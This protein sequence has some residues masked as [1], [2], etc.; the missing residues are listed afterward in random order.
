MAELSEDERIVLNNLQGGLPVRSDPFREL[1]NELDLSADRIVTTL[2]QLDERG[3]LSRFGAVL[4][5]RKMGGDS[6]LAAMRVP[7]D[8]FREVAE[9]VNDYRTVTHNYRREHTLNM[10]FVLSASDPANIDRTMEAIEDETGLEVFNLPKLTEYYV[11]LRFYFESDG[12]V[13]TVS[14][15]EN[16]GR[17]GDGSG[18]ELTPIQRQVVLAI[19]D[20]LPIT[21]RPFAV[22]AERIGK[23]EPLV[24]S[25]LREL[26]RK[27]M[28]KRLG[29][30][31]NHYALGIKGNGMAVFDVPDEEIDA[32]GERLGQRDEV[33]H[34]YRRP[35][36]G[37]VWS[38]NLF[39]MVHDRT[40]DGAR[41]LVERL[42]D[43]ENLEPY[44]YDV[45]FSEELLK[46]TGLR[47]TPKGASTA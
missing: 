31:P 16:Y 41:A 23:D 3:L 43:E 14:M 28:I 17:N 29:C 11:G 33:T 2:E 9:T 45:L 27:R 39:A 47:L 37:S 34:C 36:H 6:R 40:R 18:G 44:D 25:V 38:Y 19:Q 21:N 30:I 24:L 4:N 15:D 1:E 10:W 32:V 26:L 35:R 8:R 7:S 42:R 20:G 46:K 13:R 12:T 5:T 22:L